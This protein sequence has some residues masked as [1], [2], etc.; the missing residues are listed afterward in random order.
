MSPA[1]CRDAKVDLWFLALPNGLAEPYVDVLAPEGVKMIDLSADYRFNDDWVYGIPEMNREKIKGSNFVS[2]PGCYATGAQL[3]LLPLL[4]QTRSNAEEMGLPKLNVIHTLPS[5]VS[6]DIPE[7]A[8]RLLTR[9]TLI[10]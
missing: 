1:D 9:T 5:S 2:N 10:Y 3:A 8:R 4:D 7:L 6:A